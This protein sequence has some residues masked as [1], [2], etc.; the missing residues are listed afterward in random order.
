MT[1]ARRAG[2]RECGAALGGQPVGRPRADTADSST[3]RQRTMSHPRH[4]DYCP[5]ADPCLT[6]STSATPP[7]IRCT[8]AVTTATAL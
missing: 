2:R 6:N 3:E 1:A 7:H 4:L 5:L 8:R